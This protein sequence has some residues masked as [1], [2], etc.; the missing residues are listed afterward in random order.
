LKQYR[1][2]YIGI[3][4]DMF[5]AG[6]H[7]IRERLQPFTPYLRELAS[8]RRMTLYEIAEFPSE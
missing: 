5:G 8:D 7:D 6:E 4:W 3:H 1:V 2:R